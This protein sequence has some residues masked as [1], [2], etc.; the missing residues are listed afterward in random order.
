MKQILSNP[1]EM[2]ADSGAGGKAIALA[3]LTR[4]GFRVPRFFV[5]LPGATE[6]VLLH[7]AIKRLEKRGYRLWSRNH[8]K[9]SLP[10]GCSR[11]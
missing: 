10:F 8:S 1:A 4:A 2:N 9:N 3:D 6:Y 5:A 7:F 11:R